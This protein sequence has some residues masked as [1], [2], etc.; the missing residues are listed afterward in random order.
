MSPW[1]AG[2]LVGL[3]T[4]VALIIAILVVLFETSQ[5]ERDYREAKRRLHVRGREARRELVKEAISEEMGHIEQE[6][7]ARQ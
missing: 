5:E 3:F 2:F 1:T 4:A 6:R 7:R